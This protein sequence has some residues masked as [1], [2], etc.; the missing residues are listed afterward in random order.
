[1]GRS[2]GPEARPRKSS[3]CLRSRSLSGWKGVWGQCQKDEHGQAG[4]A[5]T[6]HCKELGCLANVCG[7][8]DFSEPLGGEGVGEEE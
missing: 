2:W 5:I 8:T 7:T 3:A 1:M 6:G 4:R